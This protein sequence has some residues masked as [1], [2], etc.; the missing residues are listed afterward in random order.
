MLLSCFWQCRKE[1][2]IVNDDAAAGRESGFV[3]VKTGITPS[4]R[5]GFYCGQREGE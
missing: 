3:P 4:Q 2:V 1:T 5:L